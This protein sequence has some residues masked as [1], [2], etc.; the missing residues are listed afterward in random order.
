MAQPLT[1]FGQLAR[2]VFTFFRY[3]S[4]T[5]IGFTLYLFAVHVI[6]AF[7]FLHDIHPVAGWVF[8]AVVVVGFAWLIGRPVY[9]FLKM[10]RAISPPELPP[11]AERRPEHLVRHLWFLSQYLDG[12]RAN[13]EWDGDEAELDKALEAVAALAK[14]ADQAGQ[15]DLAVLGERVHAF[16]R[17]TVARLLAPLDRKAGEIIRREAL[18]VGVTTAVSWNGAVDAFIV[19]W[20]NLNLVTAIARI[21][22]GRPGVRGS[23]QILRDVSGAT[24]TSAYLQDLSEMAG[25]ALGGVLGKSVGAVAAPLLDGGLNAVAT[26]RIGYVAKARCRALEAWNERTVVGAVKDAVSE[27]ARYSKDVVNEVIRTVG[28][29]V[30]DLPGKVLGGITDAF[31]SI[32]RKVAG[33]DGFEPE[34]SGA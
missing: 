17:T 27:A 28:G 20:R 15:A 29:G 3:A 31:S 11:P 4:Y 1:D 13:P 26:L 23:F 33:E 5:L 25:G 30:M 8:L 21:Y 16:E 12:L 14:E 10:P 34:P 19:F 22:Y 24:I 6:Q 18:G 7:T 32:W 9:A 2:R